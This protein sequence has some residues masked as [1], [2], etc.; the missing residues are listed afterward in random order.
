MEVNAALNA[1]PLQG[2]RLERAVHGALAAQPDLPHPGDGET[3]AR[4]RAL[5]THAADDLALVKVLEAHHDARAILHDLNGPAVAAWAVWAAE[6]PNAVVRCVDGVLDGTKAWCSGG[7]L[8]SHA[9]L[10]VQSADGTRALAAVD[11]QHLGITIDDSAWQAVGMGA[12]R[13]GE[14]R[15]DRVP[16]AW[17]SEPGAYLAR[18]GFWHGGAGI[19]ARWIASTDADSLVPHDWLAGQL[20]RGCDAFCGI[21]T[22]EDWLDYDAATIAAFVGP[23]PPADGHRHIHGANFGISADAYRRCGGFAPLA[24]SEDV[25]IVRALE[26]IDAR[27]DWSATPRV[28]TSARRDARARG[29]FGD[30]L[31]ALEDLV[32]GR[33]PMAGHV[34]PV[35]A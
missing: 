22:V 29:G 4:W 11:M 33:K 27:I 31:K 2:D 7:G 23:A 35:L 6:P 14:V 18:A 1:R 15:F 34:L 12:V 21:V 10:T 28:V 19:A 30:Y 16:A 20:R 8:V 24:C 9:L 32:H 13:S 3:R 17:V 26:A 5:A 25:A